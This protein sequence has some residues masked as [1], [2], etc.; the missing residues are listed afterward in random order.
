MAQVVVEMSGDEAKLFRSYQ[1]IIDQAA[2]LEG[3][4]KDLAKTTQQVGAQADQSFGATAASAVGKYAM[5]ILS[6]QAA[7][8][9]FGAAMAYSKANTDAAIASVEQLIQARQ[10]LNQVVDS[11][12]EGQAANDFAERLA[13]RGISRDAA[14]DI[15]SSARGAGFVGSEDMVAR[16]VAANQFSPQSAVMTAGRVRNMFGDGAMTSLQ[17]LA[18]TRA[19]SKISDL[20]IDPYLNMLPN[21]ATAQTMAGGTPAEAMAITAYVASKHQR[22]AE[23]V[24]TMSGS[25]NQLK[26][27]KGLGI[28]GQVEK[29][30]G[31]T[32]A[33]R[34]K[35]LGGSKEANFA[36]D[37]LSS[38]GGIVAGYQKQ[39]Q[40]AIDDPSGFVAQMEDIAFDPSTQQG[41]I[42]LGR[43]RK[44]IASNQLESSREARL[45]AGGFAR[46]SR[47]IEETQRNEQMGMGP[48]SRYVSNQ[49]MSQAEEMQ[50]P[51]WAIGATAKAS[52]LTPLSLLEQ[53]AAKLL[54]AGEALL[55]G[56]D[57]SSRQRA[58][59]NQ[60]PE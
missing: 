27:F 56:S 46:R 23:Y 30:R 49:V 5:G 21:L 4:Q 3:K 17:S 16:L 15:V 39:I 29:L 33:Q 55:R 47:V 37:W 48:L 45:A 19:G 12:K 52:R 24:A 2:K 25:L 7:T 42:G 36:Y 57:A 31:M 22:G 13:S 6:L 10:K 8:Q 34:T 58:S 18:G 60:Q 14:L 11:G 20:D 51:E 41:Q 9:A 32:E 54:N 35:A 1:K 43:R 40:A 50:L 44:I 38:G 28:M 53:A 59:A 26:G